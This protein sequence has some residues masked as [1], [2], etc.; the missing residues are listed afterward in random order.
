LPRIQ[1]GGERS[2]SPED[3]AGTAAATAI[4]V[5]QYL[6]RFTGEAAEMQALRCGSGSET[7]VA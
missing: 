6:Q 7:H 3:V 2:L 1:H 4:G 5:R